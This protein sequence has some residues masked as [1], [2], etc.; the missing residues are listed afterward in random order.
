MLGIWMNYI[1]SRRKSA[2]VSLPLNIWRRCLDSALSIEQWRYCRN[3]KAI[4]WAIF[5]LHITER[6]VVLWKQ[7]SFYIKYAKYPNITYYVLHIVAAGRTKSYV[8]VDVI[9]K[10]RSFEL[11]NKG[12]LSLIFLYFL[13]KHFIKRINCN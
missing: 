10:W 9:K 5:D 13:T 3:L 11:D 4:C 1:S 7:N 2:G 6:T 8:T 12:F